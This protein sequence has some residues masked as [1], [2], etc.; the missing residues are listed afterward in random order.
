M[1]SLLYMG[2][3]I[4]L[5][6]LL[7]HSSLR[8]AHMQYLP[9][10]VSAVVCTQVYHT[11]ACRPVYEQCAESG[12]EHYLMCS[13]VGR[14]TAQPPAVQGEGH[15]HPT[16]IAPDPQDPTCHTGCADLPYIRLHAHCTS[17]P[18]TVTSGNTFLH[19]GQT[20]K[21]NCQQHLIKN[22]QI[23]SGNLLFQ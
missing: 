8:I 13:K 21:Y 9:Q 4:Y 12:Q 2:L 3:Q 14:H 5:Y 18:S 15:S 7:Y 22:K 11:V 20:L 10:A 19:V 16:L 23:Y 6:N 1:C 17:K